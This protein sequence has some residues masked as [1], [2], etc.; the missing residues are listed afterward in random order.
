MR[1]PALI[2]WGFAA[3]SRQPP[4]RC[5]QAPA[6][7]PHNP[8]CPLRPPRFGALVSK[9]EKI[10]QN[11][12][13]EGR[14]AV[15]ATAVP[16]LRDRPYCPT[17]ACAEGRRRGARRLKM[18]FRR[19]RIGASANSPAISHDSDARSGGSP[20]AASNSQTAPARFELGRLT[21]RKTTVQV[22]EAS[23][24]PM[25]FPALFARRSRTCRFH[26]S[27]G[28]KRSTAVQSNCG[29]PGV[30]DPSADRVLADGFRSSRWSTGG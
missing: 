12:F 19:G 1:T 25:R 18:S 17:S 23:E 11:T 13:A 22:K 14:A 15:S 26:N 2:D 27:C 4:D 9:H 21:T 3:L 8:Q 28:A 16:G 29:G 30:R 10:F 5:A 7:R 6:T 24:R 20:S